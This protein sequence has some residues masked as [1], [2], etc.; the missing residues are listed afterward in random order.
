[1][2]LRGLN[3]LSLS[4]LPNLSDYELP[5][6]VLEGPNY[7]KLLVSYYLPLSRSSMLP[8][9][10]KV[11]HVLCESSTFPLALC[12]CYRLSLVEGLDHNCIWYIIH[13]L[14]CGN[15]W[16]DRQVE[17]S[18]GLS[19]KYPRIATPCIWSLQSSIMRQQNYCYYSRQWQGSINASRG[20]FHMWGPA[21][22]QKLQV[23]SGFRLSGLK[24]RLSL[25]LA[26]AN[27]LPS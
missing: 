11:M 4:C 8:V 24:S 18:E 3:R 25:I 17:F 2:P 9:M 5:I 23:G 26:S 15:L 27:A 13:R 16:W 7:F 1:M 21:Q 10:F 14:C 20:P 12:Y 19:S 6:W 22:Q